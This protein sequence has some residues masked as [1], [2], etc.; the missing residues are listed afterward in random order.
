M[1]K[2]FTPD[3]LAEFIRKR[4]LPES[5]RI[6]QEPDEGQLSI[7][8]KEYNIYGKRVFFVGT[9]HFRNFGDT[10]EGKKQRETYESHLTDF[11]N[12]FRKQ[13][14]QDA[15]IFLLEDSASERLETEFGFLK[16]HLT[17]REIKSIR[18][19]EPRTE[20]I[21]KEIFDSEI[22]QILSVESGDLPNLSDSILLY[23]LLRGGEVDIN[24]NNL[25]G[26]LRIIFSCMEEQ[27]FE[28]FD[29]NNPK[30][31]NLYKFYKDGNKKG[32]IDEVNT[33]IEE[34]IKILNMII[35]DKRKQFV[36]SLESVATSESD[37]NIETLVGPND[38]DSL[39]EK[40][41]QY[42][43]CLVANEVNIVRDIELAK[44]V[45]RQTSSEN[46]HVFILYGGSHEI[47]LR[48][49]MEDFARLTNNPK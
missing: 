46:S 47:R 17:E 39:R 3:E 1:I 48:P 28:Y 32:I 34:Y 25:R 36:D 9:S 37:H 5:K 44:E 8:C 20:K 30:I 38:C 31:L 27:S 29:M 35:K 2:R 16:S 41:L 26:F 33:N 23:Y 19:S 14:G 49:V 4:L 15:I 42:R 6:A 24:E 43:M 11:L 13:T 7:R 10:P 21:I 12:K 18:S 45:L 22:K 40:P